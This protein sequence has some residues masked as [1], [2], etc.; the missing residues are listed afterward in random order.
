MVTVGKSKLNV[1]CGFSAIH[2]DVS[3]II[4]ESTGFYA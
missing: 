1:L 2:D 4:I 3:Y